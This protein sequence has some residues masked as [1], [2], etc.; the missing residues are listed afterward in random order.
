MGEPLGR[1]APLPLP[2][3]PLADDREKPLPVIAGMGPF[4]WLCAGAVAIEFLNERIES[5][6]S[7]VIPTTERAVSQLGTAERN[8]QRRSCATA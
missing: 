5:E 7:I 8:R 2:A 6:I 4:D 3:P 1:L